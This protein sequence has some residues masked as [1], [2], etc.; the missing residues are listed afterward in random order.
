MT[1]VINNLQK[2]SEHDPLE[3]GQRVRGGGQGKSLADQVGVGLGRELNLG[4]VVA[5]VSLLSKHMLHMDSA[6]CKYLP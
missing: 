5:V 2:K 4:D 3:Q 6:Y 1:L